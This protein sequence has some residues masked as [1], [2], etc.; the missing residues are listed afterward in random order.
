MKPGDIW[1]A[2]I[3]YLGTHEQ[4]G[5][6]PAV[7]I[8]RVAK[9]IATIIPC[10]SNNLALRFPFTY[11]IEPNN[12]NGLSSPTVALIFHIRAIDTSLLKNKIGRLDN[13]SLADVRKLAR[14]LIG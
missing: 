10:T 11:L 7:V 13:K 3:P 9:T 6:R 2:D 4:S 5:K 14:K 8:A 12:T 1:L